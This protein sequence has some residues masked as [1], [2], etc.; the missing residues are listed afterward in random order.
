MGMLYAFL[1][2]LLR[3]FLIVYHRIRV[4]GLEHLPEQGSYI[5]VGN[6]VSYLDPFYIGAMF[7]ERIYFMAKAEAFQN[8]WIRRFLRFAGAFPVNRERPEPQTLRTAIDHLKQGRI[9]GIFPEGKIKGDN[10]FHD[11]KQGAAYLAVKSGV[12]LVPVFIEGTEQALPMGKW[13]IRPVSV[14]IRIGSRLAPPST[15]GP[16]EKQFQLTKR[17]QQELLNL[18]NSPPIDQTG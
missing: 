9:V 12:P 3:I 17:L 14:T 18:K 7:K 10:L 13:W 15:G 4:E 8:S 5:V 16:K 1:K 2:S 6:H 11:M